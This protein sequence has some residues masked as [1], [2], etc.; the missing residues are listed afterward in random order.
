MFEVGDLVK[1]Y[2]MYGDIHIVKDSGMGII[3]SATEISYL[4]H[5]QVLYTV[6]TAKAGSTLI[7]EEHCLEKLNEETLL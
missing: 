5:C 6:F 7:L 4:E 3:I 2:E 1:W